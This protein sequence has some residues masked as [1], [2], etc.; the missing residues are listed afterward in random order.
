[1]KN[2][3]LLKIMPGVYQTRV[4][5]ARVTLLLEGTISLIDTGNRGSLPFITHAMRKLGRSVKE[6][7]LVIL[8]HYHPDH[9]GSVGEVLGAAAKATAYAGAA[10]IPQIKSTRPIKAVG[11][12]TK[13]SA[14][15]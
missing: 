6:L 7:E 13:C 1:M 10:D 8:T 11:T 9:V 2:L 5:G 4:P 12:T 3:L 15:A 14:C